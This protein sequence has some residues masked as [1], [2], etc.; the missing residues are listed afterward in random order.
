MSSDSNAMSDLPIVL[1]TPRGAPY[2]TEVLKKVERFMLRP[3]TIFGVP[4]ASLTWG[5]DGAVSAD[6]SAGMEGEKFT[7]KILKA[8]AADHPEVRVFHSV[9]WPGSKGDTDHM[10]VNGNHVL[11]IDS[12]RW[13]SKRKYSVTAKGAVLRGTVNFPEGKVKMIPAMSAWRQQLPTYARVSGVVCIASEKVFVPYDNNWHKAPFKLVTGEH[14]IEYLEAFFKKTK[15]DTT[16]FIDLNVVAPIITNLI[17]PRDRRAELI[18]LKA[19][20]RK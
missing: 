13:M 11:L 6:V 18:N 4:G 15:P 16:G 8:F 5:I 7:A 10:L 1:G 9:R 2:S 12:K 3:E 14:L 17:K 19:M 20:N